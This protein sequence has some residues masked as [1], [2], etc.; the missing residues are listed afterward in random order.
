[1]RTPSPGQSVELRMGPRHA[2]LGGGD[3]REHRH[4][5]L[6]W[7]SPWGRETLYWAGE[8]HANTATEA[9]GGPP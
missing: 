8:G 2:V 1:M 7:N 6:R 3:A 9:F 5:D 4:W